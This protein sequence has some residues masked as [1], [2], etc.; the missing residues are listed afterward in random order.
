MG[1]GS[2]SSQA[3]S[4]NY[5]TYADDEDDD[6]YDYDNGYSGGAPGGPQ[7]D[8]S[9]DDEKKGPV[10]QE[11]GTVK[12]TVTSRKESGETVASA[13]LDIDTFKA[14]IGMAE[15]DESGRREVKLSIEHLKAT[16]ACEIS[17]PRHV[18]ASGNSDDVLVLETGFTS[19]ELPGN[20]FTDRSLGANQDVTLSI[21]KLQNTDLEGPLKDAVGSRPV[22]EIGI[23]R[24][25]RKLSFNNPAA[26]VKISIPYTPTEEE[27]KDPKH[28]VVW[29]ID[30]YGNIHSVPNG[31]YDPETGM[32][33]FY[34]T[35]FSRY[36]VAYVKKT[37]DDIRLSA[38]KK[39]IEV[40]ASK[41]IINGR[42]E[43]IFAPLDNIKRADFLSLLI[44]V[45][46]LDAKFESNFDDVK[47][48]A[49]YYREVGIG[50]ALGIVNGIGGNRFD[51][52]SYISRQDMMVMAGRALEY[53]EGINISE[54]SGDI[55]QYGDE[56]DISAYAVPYAA[57]F[58]SNELV[59]P[60]DNTIKPQYLVTREEAAKLIY[61]L[62]NRI[63]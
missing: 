49:Y 30:G 48:G 42:S 51:P 56:D 3:Y 13:N 39:E 63:R 17:L 60:E 21:T 45:F 25:D 62:H 36:A 55:N 12:V 29:Y 50:K 26:P 54:M 20:M 2:M 61:N 16:S 18:V 43:S 19:I 35:H 44:R 15:A 1:Y 22:I 33:T 57:Y 24:G 41:G 4:I 40:L 28:I 52:D 23:S 46:E 47:P 5:F 38:A 14:A 31:R 27:L 6:D 58:L 34:V 10:V 37:F 11:D 59:V 7:G 9:K 8:T 32:V 53:A